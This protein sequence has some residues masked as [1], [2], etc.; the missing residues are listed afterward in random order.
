MHQ[1]ADPIMK[2]ISIPLL[3]IVDVTAAVL[4][5]Q[6]RRSPA[7]IGT[8]DTMKGG[9]YID[10]LIAADISP[11]IPGQKDRDEIDRIIH[12]ELC[13]GIVSKESRAI[14]V[15]VAKRLVS[16][17]AD[18]LILGCTEVRV[19]IHQSDF[20]VPVIDTIALHCKAALEKAYEK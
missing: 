2:G 5:F 14:L 9:F 11:V 3:H 7:L 6:K 8:G 19:L 12:E 16:Q 13:K 18:C 1:L 20:S 15:A 17:G 10:R 4:N